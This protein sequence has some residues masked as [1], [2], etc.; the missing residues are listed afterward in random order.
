MGVKGAAIATL[1]VRTITGLALLSCL[2]KKIDFKEKLDFSY[3]KQLL[4]IGTPIG[5]ALFL[6]FF[7]FNIITMLVGKE[8][9][10]LAATHNILMMI[11][12]T[13]FNVPLAI[14]TALAIK[15]AYNYG[16]KKPDEIKKYS[17]SA[18]LM[19][20]SFMAL[21][22]IVLANF[23][24][25]LISIFTDNIEVINIALPVVIVAATYQIFDGF[26]VIMG[27]VLKGFKMTKTVSACVLIG[28]WFVGMPIAYYFVFN[29]GYSLKGYWLALAVSLFFMGFV[30]A[31]IAKYKFAKVKN[32]C[33]E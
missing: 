5:I 29:Q 3:M 7:A 21:C 1:L 27:G 19:G 6:E 14:S 8:A 13:T 9:G 15:V 22:G 11:S 33:R 25:Q 23:P 4:K 24:R 20:V 31:I 26:Q 2:F 28:Y 16:A 17:Y 32:E 30:Q 12:S 10:I 18:L